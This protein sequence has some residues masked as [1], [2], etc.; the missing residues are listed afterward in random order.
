MENKRTILL[1]FLGKTVKG[2]PPFL[3]GRQVAGLSSLSIVVAQSNKRLANGQN[4][5][6]IRITKNFE[7]ERYKSCIRFNFLSDV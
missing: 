1:V 3:C 5:K 4:E 2:M 7:N 6:L